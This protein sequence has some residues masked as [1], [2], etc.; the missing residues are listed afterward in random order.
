MPK[1]WKNSRILKAFADGGRVKSFGEA[2]TRLSA[3]CVDVVIGSDQS[4]T[5]AGQAATLTAIATARKCFGKATLVAAVDVPLLTPLPLGPTLLKAAR[6]LGATVRSSASK[7][8]THTI[9]IGAASRSSGWD[10]RCWW[11]RWLSG[12]RAFD[13]EAL[14]DSR[15]PLSGVFAAATAV[16]QVFACVLANKNLRERDCTVSLWRPWERADLGQVG[17][18][19][20]DVPDKLWFLGLGHLGQAFI[21][22]L[23]FLPGAAERLA[24]LQDDQTV[25]EENEATSLLVLPGEGEKGERKTRLSAPWL[26]ACG[27]RTQLIERRH[28]GDIDLTD[29]DPPFLL[30][31]L[32]RLKPRLT[33]AK[34]GFPYMLDAGI[35]H[36]PGDFEGIQLRTVVG[37]KPVNGLWSDPEKATSAEEGNKGL[38]ANPAYLELEQ[39]VGVC[40]KLSFA[41]AS[42]AVPFVGAATGALVIAQAVRLASLQ[43]APLLLQ[44]ELGAPDMATVGGLTAS[45]EINLG[46]YS[47]RL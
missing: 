15:L 21:W 22:N 19:R 30:S 33:L 3:V 13:H 31:G 10:V 23:C 20:F 39:H 45:P 24:V 25:G 34:H 18:E 43:P 14:G 16:R 11:D 12:T 28:W 4:A 5:I 42:V 7:K 36:G 29:A 1:Y 47:V 9:R 26:E 6:A 38:L 32:D 37:G 35:G 8:A 27:W 40:G 17:P 2:E 44:M 46:S 41:E